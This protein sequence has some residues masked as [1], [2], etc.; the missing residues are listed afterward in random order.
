[1]RY[2]F[3][4][5]ERLLREREAD[6]NTVNASFE[7]QKRVIVDLEREIEAVGGRWRKAEE[8]WRAEREGLAV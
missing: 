1:M 8:E 7:K 5:H 3:E 6:L 4:Q 2:V